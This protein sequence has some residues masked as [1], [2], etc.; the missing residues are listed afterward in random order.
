MEAEERKCEG[1]W[2]GE[3]KRLKGL[4]TRDFFAL[5]LPFSFETRLPCLLRVVGEKAEFAMLVILSQN[6]TVGAWAGLRAPVEQAVIGI[7]GGRP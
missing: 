6:P 7:R 1:E 4:F 5:P 3:D 2:G